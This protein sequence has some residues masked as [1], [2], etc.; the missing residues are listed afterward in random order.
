MHV[1]NRRHFGFLAPRLRVQSP[2]DEP[3]EDLLSSFLVPAG[4]VRDLLKEGPGPCV[5]MCLQR[6]Q[7][8]HRDR[9]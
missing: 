1:D 4:F 9:R 2:S 6:I 3:I 8:S 7:T 5:I